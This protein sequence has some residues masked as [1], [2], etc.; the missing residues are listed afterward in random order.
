[1]FQESAVLQ[2]Y[3]AAMKRQQEGDSQGAE[4]IYIEILD[5]PLISPVSTREL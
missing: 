4:Q 5:S 3:H 2:L 1:M